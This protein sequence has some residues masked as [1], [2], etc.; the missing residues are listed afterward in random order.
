MRYAFFTVLIVMH[1]FCYDVAAGNITFGYRATVVNQN[2]SNLPAGTILNGVI[3]IDPAVSASQTGGTS[4]AFRD[5]I[6]LWELWKDN[7]L[8][9]RS[10]DGDVYVDDGGTIRPPRGGE[11]EAGDPNSPDQVT[12]ITLGAVHDPA[13]VIQTVT[14]NEYRLNSMRII[15]NDFDGVALSGEHLPTDELTSNEF[16]DPLFVVLGFLRTDGLTATFVSA[17]LL[18]LRRIDIVPEPAT[19]IL[20]WLASCLCAGRPRNTA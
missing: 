17:N 19:M 8:I 3:E 6:T 9:G 15:M 5:A 7:Q 10:A 4:V 16:D 1:L 13:F 14:G 18:S 11:P 12:L 2:V 20:A